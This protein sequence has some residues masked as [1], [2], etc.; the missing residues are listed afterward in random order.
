[1][2]LVFICLMV[3]GVGLIVLDFLVDGDGFLFFLGCVFFGAGIIGLFV[4]LDNQDASHH[5]QA[6]R[7]IRAAGWHFD[8]DQ[9]DHTESVTIHCVTFDIIKVNGKYVVAAKRPA[10]QGGGH[11]ILDP[12]KTQDRL[13]PV[14]FDG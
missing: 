6:I 3:A 4:V 8:S 10:E 14:C 11:I 5:K 12:V 9:V 1:M 2:L 13:N 7:D